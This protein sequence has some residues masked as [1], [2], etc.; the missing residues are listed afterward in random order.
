MLLQQPAHGG[1]QVLA[2]RFLAAGA[3]PR[4][5]RARFLP[6]VYQESSLPRPDQGGIRLA[7]RLRRQ[8]RYLAAAQAGLAPSPNVHRKT[9][10]ETLSP[11]GIHHLKGIIHSLNITGV[12]SLASPR[13]GTDPQN[14]GG[15]KK[16]GNAIAFRLSKLYCMRVGRE[17]C[18]C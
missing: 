1:V 5:S 14:L 13:N 15:G 8:L 11:G 18:R 4:P 7:G 12:P 3:A 17:S 9:L 10:Q 2:E 16:P 6:Q